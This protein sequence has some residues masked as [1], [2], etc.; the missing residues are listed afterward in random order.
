MARCLF[1]VVNP[2][3]RRVTDGVEAVAP[4]EVVRRLDVSDVVVRQRSLEARMGLK[5][6]SG[7]QP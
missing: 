6:D 7:R 1:H 5:L 4:V 3:A 2:I